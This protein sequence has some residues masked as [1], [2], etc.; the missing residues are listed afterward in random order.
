MFSPPREHE[1]VHGNVGPVEFSLQSQNLTCGPALR[2]AQR[3]R[4]PA[5]VGLLADT[6]GTE[7]G[8]AL[9]IHQSYRL[10]IRHWDSTG[11]W[12]LSKRLKKGTFF[13]PKGT[14]APGGKLRLK[15]EANSLL[16]DGVDVREASMLSW[17]ERE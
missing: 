3:L 2:H 11:S 17:H 10:N 14:E 7:P 5:R 4:S 13:W 6:R 9:C 15:T 1:S 8:E 12:I 16:T